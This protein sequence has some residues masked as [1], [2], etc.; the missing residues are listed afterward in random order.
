MAAPA[1]PAEAL[2]CLTASSC[3]ASA[4]LCPGTLLPDTLRCPGI[5]HCPGLPSAL[6]PAPAGPGPW[7]TAPQDT[8]TARAA[9]P[10]PVLSTLPSVM[11]LAA[12]TPP[13]LT[14]SMNP[15]PAACSPTALHLHGAALLAPKAR[16]HKFNATG[17]LWPLRGQDFGRHKTPAAR[18]HC[19]CK[20]LRAKA[21]W[22]IL[23][24]RDPPSQS[25]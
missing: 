19:L 5:P 2:A 14:H 13:K 16:R 22:G 17:L 8:G 1:S 21:E 18:S 24:G 11:V 15:H 10:T 9:G 25:P 7:H 4:G 20:A 6:T 12:P 23:G 3:S